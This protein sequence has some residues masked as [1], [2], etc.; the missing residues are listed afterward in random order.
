MELMARI[1]TWLKGSLRGNHTAGFEYDFS[2]CAQ[3]FS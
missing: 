1:V 3:M 2:E